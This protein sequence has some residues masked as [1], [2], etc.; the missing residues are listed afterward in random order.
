MTHNRKKSQVK[1]NAT[2]LGAH[3]KYAATTPSC[4]ILSGF[5]DA[6]ACAAGTGSLPSP[7]PSPAFCWGTE[8][9][10]VPGQAANYPTRNIAGRNAHRPGGDKLSCPREVP[11]FTERV[12]SPSKQPEPGFPPRG[13]SFC[14]CFACAK[15]A[16][17]SAYSDHENNT[18]E[19]KHTSVLVSPQ[20][21]HRT[22]HIC[23]K[24]ADTSSVLSSLPAL[25]VLCL[26]PLLPG[27]ASERKRSFPWGED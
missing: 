3:R 26:S 2:Q 13:S 16:W 18:L 24:A 21:Q 25:D 11:C 10:A 6:A 20:A 9:P 22:A 19:I 4:C 8:A 27:R 17:T 15:P 5:Q 14:Y 7:G 1:C 12:P 23:C